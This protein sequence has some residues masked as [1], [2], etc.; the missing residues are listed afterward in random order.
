[1]AIITTI[2]DNQCIGDSLVTINNNFG[3]LNNYT[4]PTGAILP[5][6]MSTAPTGWLACDGQSYSVSTYADLFVAI[7]YTYGGAGSNFNVPNLQGQFIRGLTTNLTT[8][9]QD[10]LSATRTLGSLQTDSFKSHNH[11][12]PYIASIP[13]NSVPGQPERI[14]TENTTQGVFD[15]ATDRIS[16]TGGTET[17]PVNIALFYCIKF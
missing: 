16:A 5:F 15:G 17:R 7:K 11:S 6:A 14:L 13:T 10:P 4:V 2:P 1:M 8:T 3:N 9:S 12:I